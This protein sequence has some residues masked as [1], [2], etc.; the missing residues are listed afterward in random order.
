MASEQKFVKSR[1]YETYNIQEIK[2]EHKEEA[3][4]DEEI[5]KDEEATVPL[6]TYINN[7]LNSFFSKVDVYINKQ[8]I[9]N[10][11]SLYSHKSYTSNN[12]KGAIFENKGN[13]QCKWYD[14]GEFFDEFWGSAFVWTFFHKKNEIA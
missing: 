12:L 3:K 14:C 2:K 11:N 1:G 10:S 4:A 7:I 5:R 6:V 8:Q 13:L 9:Y